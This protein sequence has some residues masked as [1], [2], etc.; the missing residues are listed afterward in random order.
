[1]TTWHSGYTS[2]EISLT[3]PVVPQ[4]MLTKVLVTPSG[5]EPLAYRLGGGRSILL[6]YG[7]FIKFQLLIM[8]WK[9]FS[10]FL[11]SSFNI[12]RTI[13]GQPRTILGETPDQLH[14]YLD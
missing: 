6:S 4:I 1:M 11:V 9:Y 7:A 3:K 10:L 13:H 5:F 2:V 12:H 8:L 14:D